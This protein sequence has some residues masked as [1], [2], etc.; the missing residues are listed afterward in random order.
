MHTT[1]SRLDRSG[2]SVVGSSVYRR[3]LL[4]VLLSRASRHMVGCHM[5]RSGKI[6]DF[7]LEI[8]GNYEIMD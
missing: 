5:G 7:A 6:Y 2:S 8:Y 1:A 3:I 4:T